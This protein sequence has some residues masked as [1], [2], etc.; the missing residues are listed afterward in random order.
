MSIINF[1]NRTRWIRDYNIA[2][3]CTPIKIAR[4]MVSLIDEKYF[5]PDSK[6]LDIYCKS[7]TILEAIKD[8]LMD[9]KSMIEAFPSQRDRYYHVLEHQIYGLVWEDVG[10]NCEEMSNINVFGTYVN[11]NIKMFKIASK[12]KKDAYKILDNITFFKDEIQKIFGEKDMKFNI[13]VGNPPYNNDAY[14]DFVKAGYQ[15]STQYSTFITPAKWQAKEGYKNEQFRETIVPHMSKIVYYPDCV[16]VFGISELGGISYYTID[17]N[18]IHD[19]KDIINKCELQPL[20]NSSMNREINSTLWNSAQSI[21]E[22]IKS[23]DDYKLYVLQD[24]K[25][26]RKTCTI[27]INKQIPT[28]RS[29]IWDWNNS[30]IDPKYVGHGGC[31]LN[32]NDGSTPLLGRAKFLRHAENGSGTSINIFTSDSELECRSF[33]SWVYSKFIRFLLIIALCSNSVM[34]DITWRFVPDPG[35]FDHIFT[36]KELYEKY[37]L[38]EDEINIIE[39]I[40]KERK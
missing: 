25:Q 20:L 34:N 3:T 2:K 4:D 23:S 8:R 19:T 15:L 29:H 13:V 18:N 21:I 14:L 38:T 24:I 31:L 30:C 10:I 22:K 36:D 16:D 26:N 11:S 40:I 9:S 28:E 12:N 1:E 39:S 27:N 35:K 37:N 7:G 17:K 33:T 6:F 32:K 5:N